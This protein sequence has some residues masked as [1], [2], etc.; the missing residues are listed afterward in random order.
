MPNMPVLLRHR[1]VPGGLQGVQQW[2][3]RDGKGEK[4]E[5]LGDMQ[6]V[7]WAVRLRE[8]MLAMCGHRGLARVAAR[9]P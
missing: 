4:W 3:K 6:D 7:Q 8:G 5:R 2:S 1:H 9:L